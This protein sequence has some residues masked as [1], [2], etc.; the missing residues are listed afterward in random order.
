MAGTILSYGHEHP[1]VR[2]THVGERR[3]SSRTGFS[4]G[5]RA[6]PSKGAVAAGGMD[7]LPGQPLVRLIAWL[8]VDHPRG[9]N[10]ALSVQTMLFETLWRESPRTEKFRGYLERTGKEILPVN[11]W[12]GGKAGSSERTKKNNYNA[13]S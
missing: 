7:G 10:S 11:H 4:W 9:L 13:H 12:G 5:G 1:L 6:E 8:L 3:E 2:V